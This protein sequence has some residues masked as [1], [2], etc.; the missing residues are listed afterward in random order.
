MIYLLGLGLR[1]LDSVTLL[2]D[3]IIS[4]CDR[5]Y[6]ESYTSVSPES[7]VHHLENHYGK[8]V[9]PVLREDIENGAAILEEAKSS[10]VCLLVTGDPLYATTHNQIR[11]DAL[12]SGIRLEVIENSS[13]LAVVPGRVGL[14]PYRMGPPVSLPFVSER[15][16]PRSVLDKIGKNLAAELHTLLLL[17]LVSGRTMYPWEA[18]TTRH[19]PCI[20]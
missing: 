19:C 6:F 10:D 13:V 15:F 4:S 11:L 8:R 3:R 5:I 14:F 2:E 16:M 18:A 17:D 20:I 9:I 1:G 12:K 7:T